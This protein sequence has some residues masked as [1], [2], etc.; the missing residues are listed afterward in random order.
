MESEENIRRTL[1]GAKINVIGEIAN[2]IDLTNKKLGIEGEVTINIKSDY[3]KGVVDNSD[4]T[5]ARTLVGAEAQAS[6]Y[7]YITSIVMSVAAAGSYWIEDDD[8]AQITCKFTL[9]AN[10]GL[11]WTA[12]DGTPFKSK[13]VNK[14][15]K[16]K[17]STAGA[18]GCMITFYA[19]T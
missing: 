2:C 10:G 6:K 12:G 15:L 13:T 14:G 17:G 19:A 4:T 7:F 16:V 3:G 9:A 5:T 1:D 18:V 8:A 11:S